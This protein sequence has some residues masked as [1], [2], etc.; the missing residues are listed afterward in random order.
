MHTL[1][2]DINI[3]GCSHWR[4]GRTVA[5]LPILSILFITLN[6]V[7]DGLRLTIMPAKFISHKEKKIIFLIYGV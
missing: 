5:P 1:Q 4:E 2:I 7:V 3:H 6:Q